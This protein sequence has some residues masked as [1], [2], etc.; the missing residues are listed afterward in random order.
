VRAALAALAPEAVAYVSCNPLTLARDLD[1]LARL[2]LVAARMQ[3]LDMMP[4][5]EEVETIALL[6]PA[7]VP[8]PRVLYED[9]RL[10][11]VDKPAH[12]STTPQGERTGSLL[13]RVRRLPGCGDAVP[14]HRLDADTSGVCWF[15]RHAS[16]VE[17]LAALL[18]FS[19]KRYLALVR[20]VTSAKGA[21]NRALREG[22]S[23]IPARTR[24]RRL[25]VCGGH[26]LLEVHPEQ[27]RKHQVRRHLAGLGHPVVGDRRYGHDATNRHFEE[28]YGLDRAFLHCQSIT[29]GT[30]SSAH[31][32]ES[33]LPAELRAILGALAGRGANMKDPSRPVPVL[34]RVSLSK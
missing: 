18:T 6:R 7:P 2:G 4:L 1:A 33:P 34:P 20:G 14:V 26:S 22:G 32:F 29:F 31:A 3:P 21:V 9:D 17:E 30:R 24:Y 5:T 13:D 16:F 11:V 25:E 8:S 23:E 15:A 27:G 10:L 19:S 28:R 12:E